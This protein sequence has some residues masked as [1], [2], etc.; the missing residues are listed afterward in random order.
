MLWPFTKAAR[1]PESYRRLVEEQT[2]HAKTRRDLEIA[3]A[4]ID[5][6]SLVIA[7]D[8]ERVKSEL[9]AYARQRAENEGQNGRPE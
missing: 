7:R 1:E 6:L 4:E 8:R 2:A 3:R 9:S 5:S